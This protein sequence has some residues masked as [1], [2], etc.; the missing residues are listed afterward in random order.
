[1][2]AAATYAAFL[3]ATAAAAASVADLVVSDAVASARKASDDLEKIDNAIDAELG[4]DFDLSGFGN[5]I[6]DSPIIP[7]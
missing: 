3:D 1:M 2:T 5:Y 4:E 6:F 7:G